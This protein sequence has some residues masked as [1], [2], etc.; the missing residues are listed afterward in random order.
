MEQPPSPIA[1]RQ[2]ASRSQT[3]QPPLSP[4]VGSRLPVV[5]LRALCG[6]RET[7]LVWMA[8]SL[9]GISAVWSSGVEGLAGREPPGVSDGAVIGCLSPTGLERK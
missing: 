2:M 5:K 9:C 7:P 4:A 8:G 1:A 6:Q 3:L